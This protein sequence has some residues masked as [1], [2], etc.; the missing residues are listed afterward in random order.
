MKGMYT[1]VGIPSPLEF[2]EIESDLFPRAFKE[3]AE[4]VSVK[5]QHDSFDT[6]CIEIAKDDVQRFTESLYLTLDEMG[7]EA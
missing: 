1:C 7:I 2:G 4:N 5:Y 3:A 6:S